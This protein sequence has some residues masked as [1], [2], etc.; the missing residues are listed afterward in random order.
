M[1]A[2]PLPSRGPKRGRKCY[3]TPTFSGVPNKGSKIRNGCLTP[4]FLGAQKRA[5]M[6]HHPRILRGP[7]QRGAKS[8][9]A[10]SPNSLQGVGKKEMTHVGQVQNLWVRRSNHILNSMGRGGPE[11]GGGVKPHKLAPPVVAIS[12]MGLGLGVTELVEPVLVL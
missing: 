12:H 6:L 4:A 2:L 9:M 1:A 8:E 3:I 7:Q 5:E 10:A 11:G